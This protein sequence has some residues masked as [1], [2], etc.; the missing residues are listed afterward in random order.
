[1]IRLLS[2]KE[3]KQKIAQNQVTI[4][5]IYNMPKL[6]CKNHYSYCN[7]LRKQILYQC[8]FGTG[9][10]N[11]FKHALPVQKQQIST[12]SLIKKHSLKTIL[13]YGLF[14]LPCA[15][16]SA[17][18]V[19]MLLLTNKKYIYG[20]NHLNKRKGKVI[21][22]ILSHTLLFFRSTVSL[23]TGRLTKKSKWQP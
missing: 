6:L 19:R 9:Q 16:C 12:A 11:C 21:R 14:M 17:H 7:V 13:Q 2:H 20:G 22:L 15:L 5:T 18:T 8:Q 23:K 10:H 4:F 1:M 3:L